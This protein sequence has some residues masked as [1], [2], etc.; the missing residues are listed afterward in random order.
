MTQVI[1]QR[2]YDI[3]YT[4]LDIGHWTQDIKHRSYD[5]GHKTQ[6]IGMGN[7]PHN[8]KHGDRISDSRY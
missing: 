5:T 6:D 1:V 7:F 4:L 2:I 8:I 3:V